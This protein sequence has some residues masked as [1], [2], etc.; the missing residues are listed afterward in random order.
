MGTLESKIAATEATAVIVGSVAT[1]TIAAIETTVT[2]KVPVK[3][4][5]LVEKETRGSE[6]QAH[7]INCT[8]RKQ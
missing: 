1:E 6:F 7:V 5:L 3:S 2:K 4:Q 8:D